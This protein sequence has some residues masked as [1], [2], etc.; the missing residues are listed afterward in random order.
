MRFDAIPM[1]HFVAFHAA[2]HGDTP[3]TFGVCSKCGGACEQSKVGTLMPG[4]KEYI[5]QASGIDCDDFARRYLDVIEMG[6]GTT[7]DV[8][9]MV[10]GCPFLTPETY[11]CSCRGIKPI[12]CDIYPVVFAVESDTVRFFLDDWCPLSDLKKV[13]Q[14]FADVAIPLLRALPVPL[15]W[16]RLVETYDHLYFDYAAIER[17]RRSE[18][19]EL[20]PIAWLLQFQ[21]PNLG[22][23]PIER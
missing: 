17:A 2:F 13:R 16:Y 14:Y 19:C 11:E 1:H 4:E 15:D 3:A 12:M 10:D 9:K 23:E 7:L 8:L 5:A 22:M 21:N 6:D 20:F 18:D